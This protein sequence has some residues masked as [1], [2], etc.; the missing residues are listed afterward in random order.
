M[1]KSDLWLSLIQNIKQVSIYQTGKWILILN[2][3]NVLNVKLRFGN[4]PVGGRKLVYHRKLRSSQKFWTKWLLLVMFCVIHAVWE[5]I[6]GT[7]SCKN[8]KRQY[9][10]HRVINC[11]SN[12]HL[13]KDRKL[14]NRHLLQLG[15]KYLFLNLIYQT[16]QEKIHH[17]IWM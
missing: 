4:H 10:V 8:R 14:K 15:L 11:L 3:L 2:I 1:C 5:F 17:I 6:K 16:L 7:T 13:F 12:N 9:Q